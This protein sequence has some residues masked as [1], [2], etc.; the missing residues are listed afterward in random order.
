MDSQVAQH[1]NSINALCG[2]VCAR[3]STALPEEMKNNS[4]LFQGL[5]LVLLDAVRHHNRD[6]MNAC[7]EARCSSPHLI[8]QRFNEH[9]HAALWVAQHTG[10]ALE[11]SLSPLI[12]NYYAPSA[13]Q[14]VLNVESQ[15]WDLNNFHHAVQQIVSNHSWTDMRIPTEALEYLAARDAVE[16]FAHLSELFDVRTH[17]SVW[18]KVGLCAVCYNAKS[19]EDYILKVPYNEQAWSL[20]TLGCSSP[21]DIVARVPPG[22][23]VNF[24]IA[25]LERANGPDPHRYEPLVDAL[26]KDFMA[27][28]AQDKGEM[29]NYL[30]QKEHPLTHQ[31]KSDLENTLQKERLLKHIGS[32]N[33]SFSKSK[34]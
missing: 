9:L 27:L 12:Q 4:T 5:P 28:S 26:S 11:E 14:Y 18:E 31:L 10:S 7:V 34:M 30:S 1:L 15:R 29:L 24:L 16:E 19:V 3:T 25:V 21:S 6:L 8:E 22:A 32:P 23:R 20:W 33:R 2:L 13:A 17:P